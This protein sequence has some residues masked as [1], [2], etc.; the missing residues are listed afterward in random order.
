[1]ISE[2][3]IIMVFAD[4]HIVIRKLRRRSQKELCQSF[5]DRTENCSDFPEREKASGPS[6]P[7]KL[8]LKI[9]NSQNI[10][11]IDSNFC[12]NPKHFK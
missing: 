6:Y 10:F 7:N 9:N 1:M 11:F 5:A 3:F 8:I 4:V 12:K 2:A